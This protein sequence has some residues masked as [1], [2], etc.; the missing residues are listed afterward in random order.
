MKPRPTIS[1]RS[2]A[3]APRRACGC[4]ARSLLALMLMLAASFAL[5]DGLAGS[6]AVRSAGLR[7]RGGVYLLDA[8][9]E[10][11]IG[12]AVERGLANGVPLAL[13]VDLEVKRVRRFLPDAT[14]ADLTQRYRL[15]Y[16]AV[17]ARYVLRNDN[18]GEQ[19][20][21]PTLDSALA[22]LSTVRGLPVLDTSLIA[23]P[24]QYE[25]SVRARI[26]YGTVPLTLRTARATGTRGR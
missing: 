26:D 3:L 11:P 17:S 23:S 16:N 14:V 24:G 25:A 19:I 7:L 9:F 2:A 10:L 1:V 12:A 8:R 15:Q 22:A 4:S 6:L 21:L 5:A 13:E 20:S 18:S